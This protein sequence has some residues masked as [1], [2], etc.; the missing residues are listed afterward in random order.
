[1]N[2]ALENMQEEV[3]IDYFMIQFR[4]TNERLRKVRKF[5]VGTAFTVEIGTGYLINY[6]GINTRNTKKPDRVHCYRPTS[7]NSK[8]QF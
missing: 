1:M 8:F 7:Y 6:N 2:C 4:L 3:S 5:A